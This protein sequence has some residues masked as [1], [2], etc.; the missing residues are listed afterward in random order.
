V[1]H[2]DPDRRPLF[3]RALD[4]LAD[5]VLVVDVAR[6]EAQ[7]VDVRVE[8]HEREPVV[9]VDVRDD[10]QDRPA[11]DLLERLAAALVRHGHARDL[12]AGF[13][14]ELDL[15]DRRVDVVGERRAH[16]LDRDGSAVAD[17][18]TAHPDALRLTSRARGGAVLGKV[19]IDVHGA[20]I[21]SVRVPL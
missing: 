18:G 9:E 6:I 5:P 11:N 16:R 10:R 20:H 15:P 8:R 14:Q 3:L 4:D 12:A 1:V 13:L 17:G 21:E 7:L 19:E 2:A